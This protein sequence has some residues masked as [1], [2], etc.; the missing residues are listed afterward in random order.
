[1]AADF[2]DVKRHEIAARMKELEAAVEEYRRLEAALAALDA[3]VTPAARPRPRPAAPRKAAATGARRRGRPKGSGTRRAEAL[4]IVTANPGIT[5][6]EIAEQLGIN[7][8]YLY[9]VLPALAKDGLI[10]RSGR[11]WR[12]AGAE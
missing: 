2:L 11:G 5:V 10:V 4:A 6:A 8:N 7:Q 9:R 12:A 1:M 3:V